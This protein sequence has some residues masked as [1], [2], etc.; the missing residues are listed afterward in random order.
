MNAPTA[1][2]ITV[3]DSCRLLL[4]Y[5]QTQWAEIVAKLFEVD[6]SALAQVGYARHTIVPH[7][8]E[9][10]RGSA[11]RRA[12]GRS[13]RSAD[14]RNKG[15]QSRKKSGQRK[16]N[17][18]SSDDE[19]SSA[20]SSAGRHSEELSDVSGS[21]SDEE[22]K[23]YLHTPRRPPVLRSRNAVQH[24]YHH[25]HGTLGITSA[26]HISSHDHQRMHWQQ[27][28]PRA[29]SDSAAMPYAMYQSQQPSHLHQYLQL[30]SQYKQSSR[31]GY[32]A[33]GMEAP[34]STASLHT[35]SDVSTARSYH[36]HQEHS[37]LQHSDESGNEMEHAARGD[38][39]VHH[40]ASSELL[41]SESEASEQEDAGGLP[42]QPTK[43]HIQSPPTLTMHVH[44]SLHHQL[45][46]TP[47]T[48]TSTIKVEPASPFTGSSM[49]PEL[50]DM[51]PFLSSPRS[52]NV[53]T[54]LHVDVNAPL[55]S[56]LH[57][58]V[59]TSPAMMYVPTST[60]AGSDS[61]MHFAQYHFPSQMNDMQIPPFPSNHTTAGQLPAYMHPLPSPIHSTSTLASV[62]AAAHYH[63]WMMTPPTTPRLHTPASFLSP[64]TASTR[65]TGVEAHR[66][67]HSPF[68]T[69]HQSS[70]ARPSS[71]S[72]TAAMPSLLDSPRSSQFFSGHH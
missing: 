29:R 71:S 33:V 5:D 69:V 13:K 47:L 58:G 12:A 2:W 36:H 21:G 66:P 70:Q 9:Y 48:P 1:T 68:Q 49:R 59:H 20:V 64:V 22:Y 37:Q 55:Q 32:S 34:D 62:P 14:R 18:V 6:L 61:H 27:R 57:S 65:L 30:K 51:S 72:A 28:E 44:P 16:S 35:E 31:V 56:S 50:L 43:V 63:P 60:A 11:G 42:T 38:D 25:S 26:T 45:P 54:P 24:D 23:P 41:H 67:A 17:S 19:E 46:C 52:G 10:S 39:M 3:R 8:S 53:R 4:R 40:G 7:Q 15:R